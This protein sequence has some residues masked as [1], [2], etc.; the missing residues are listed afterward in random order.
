MVRRIAFFLPPVAAAVT[1]SAPATNCTAFCLPKVVRPVA[2]WGF[3][4]ACCP[5]PGCGL[6]LHGGACCGRLGTQSG[7]WYCPGAPPS[8][9]LSFLCLSICLCLSVCLS[10]SLFLAIV[11]LPLLSRIA[12][13]RCLPFLFVFIAVQHRRLVITLPAQAMLDLSTA[14]TR[15]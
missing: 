4:I 7:R 5:W 14:E 1:P 6:V 9:S 2:L 8:L 10:V 11:R 12:I 15:T 13:A 3:D